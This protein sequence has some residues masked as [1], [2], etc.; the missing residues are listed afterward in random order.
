M[1]A[2]MET[3]S[4]SVPVFVDDV[5]R[6]PGFEMARCA[7]FLIECEDPAPEVGLTLQDVALPLLIVGMSAVVHRPVDGELF[8]SPERIDAL[9][10]L[11]ERVE[12]LRVDSS[13]IWLPNFLLRYEGRRQ[14]RAHVYR[15]GLELFAAAY[16]HWDRRLSE[17]AFIERCR[18]ESKSCRHSPVE[19][20]TFAQWTALQIA[21]AR[22]NYT[23]QKER[24]Q[25]LEW[26]AAGEVSG[27]TPE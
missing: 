8:D 11:I 13:N 24:N 17:E 21:G 25:V 12:T 19:T 20:E 2:K 23:L 15:I 5:K 7:Y 6:L 10:E 22:E 14:E 16:R 26:H 1:V 18:E 9:F 27:Y 4:A 3:T